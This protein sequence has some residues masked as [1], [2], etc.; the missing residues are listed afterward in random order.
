MPSF[1]N[2]FTKAARLLT[3]WELRGNMFFK[4]EDLFSPFGPGMPNGSKL[5]AAD[6]IFSLRGNATQIL[7]AASGLS[8][9]HAIVAALA[10]LY[11]L[12]HT[13]ITAARLSK[14]Y[15]S[16]QIAECLGAKFQYSKVGYQPALNAAVN[17][18]HTQTPGSY[19]LPYGLTVN[20]PEHYRDF[21]L[22]NAPQTNNT[23]SHV[24]TLYVP[25][26]SC[27]TLISVLIG[28]AANPHNVRSV[29]SVGVGPDKL[30]WV[31]QRLNHMGFN[32]TKF[33]FRW[34]TDINLHEQGYASYTDKMPEHFEGID[35]HPTYE[36]KIWRYLTKADVFRFDGTEGFWVVG[37]QLGAK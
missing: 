4:R 25:A 33:P 3:P 10:H 11:G 26:G 31:T 9:Q 19:I 35:F 2:D 5:R 27:N 23:P 15:P 24:R 28:L 18:L 37:G 13:H 20:N 1:R 6:H 21:Y 12:P 36:G 32:P 14:S 16:L 8:P 34:N 22:A 29:I 30:A 17:A 7:T